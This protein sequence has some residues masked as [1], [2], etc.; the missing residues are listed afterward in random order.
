MK[1]IRD[2]PI[3]QKMLGMTML[4][5]GGVLCVAITSFFAFQLLNFRSNFRRDSATLAVIIAN[6]STAAMAFKDEQAAAEVV[7]ALQADPKV[8]AA[9]LILPDGS[10]F[11][12]FGKTEDAQTL[13]QFPS[14]G[15][16]RFVD[17]DLL[18]TQP[19]KLN[20]EQLG[21]LYLRSDYR[22]TF[23]D[24]LGFYGKVVL[25]VM[26]LSISLAVF[27]SSQ[28][29]RT[30]TNPILHLA[31]I[32][33]V[34]GEK[35]DY[36][37]RVKVGARGDELGRLAESFNE[38]LSR[39][40]SQDAA[41]SLSQQRMEALINS[42]V[43]IVWER[44][45]DT[46]QFTFVSRQSEDI[47][48]YPPQAWLD[49]PDFWEQKLHP[50][51]AAKAIHTG[52]EMA[53]RTQSYTY[54]Y[55]MIAA[56]G[57]TVWIR[58]SGTVLVEQGKPVAMRGI[59]LDVTREKLDAEQLDKLNRQLMSTSRLAG[60]A[61]VATGVL[62]NVG[63]VLNSVSVSA[64]AVAE[65]LR[66]SKLSNLQ[67]ATALLR[68]Q[69]GQLAQFLTTDPKGKILPEYLAS[70]ADQLAG[71]QKNLI[72][73]MDSVNEHVEHI[74]EIVAM[75]QSYAKVSGVYENLAV[76]A[77]VEDALRMNA[78]AF[79][80]HGIEI[81]RH[82]AGNIPPVCVD[83][84]KVLQILINLVRNAKYAMA[85]QDDAS[86][87][88]TVRVEMTSPDRVSIRIADN[89]VGIAPENLTRIFNHGFTTKK[90][91]HGF[92]L[93][94]GANAAKEMGGTLIAHSEGPGKGA[95]FTLDLPTAACARQK[96]TSPTRTSI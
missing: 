66:Q 77:L 83:R 85:S 23:L 19:V 76:V 12:H 38:M 59:F 55:R 63:N 46:F 17:G 32:A 42:I 16:W 1:L 70:V 78:A 51:D 56:G 28:L 30:I 62:H 72:A 73:K 47:L 21:M 40:Q 26:F 11:A 64:T 45:P 50:Q 8:L 61:E 7:G 24:L 65:R 74:K 9:T 88:L 15:A 54:E 39:I 90:D 37:L 18:V 75:Q 36:S 87:R 14:P 10:P 48:G 49:Q 71:E 81:V 86:K 2:L 79:D 92:G 33:R 35:K 52:A 27:L 20:R 94:S 58:E 60:M 95:E 44:K 91:G 31:Q 4:I 22:R 43:G 80:R 96:E 34:V 25:G 6:N 57:R 82:F 41:L 5:C 29:G 93:H 3:Q 68:E 69:N 53:A 84:H 13:S 89:G 67:R